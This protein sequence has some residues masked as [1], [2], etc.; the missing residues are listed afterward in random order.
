MLRG[1]PKYGIFTAA[2]YMEAMRGVIFFS[3]AG[4]LAVFSDGLA[5]RF[6][7]V[8]IQ[9]IRIW[10]K[11]SLQDTSKNEHTNMIST[12][13][14]GIFSASNILLSFAR[15]WS[16]STTYARARDLFKQIGMIVSSVASIAMYTSKSDSPPQHRIALVYVNFSALIVLVGSEQN[17]NSQRI[18]PPEKK[19]ARLWNQCHKGR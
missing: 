4:P 14:S 17:E 2:I 11:E 13:K 8:S 16:F 6:A 3:F 1:A 10:T 9:F 19:C 5:R 7:N 18:K 12:R 15:A